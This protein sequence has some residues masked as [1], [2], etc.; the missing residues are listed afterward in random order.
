MARQ[1][2]FPTEGKGIRF[3]KHH[4][5]KHGVQFDKYFAIRYAVDR[6]LK[7]EAIGWSSEGWTLEKVAAIREELLSNI[8]SGNGPQSY[9]EMNE[10]TDEVPT[11]KK[12]IEKNYLERY[13]KK[14]KRTWK[15]DERQLCK[16][17]IPAI[18]SK[19]LDKVTKKDI[20]RIL[21]KAADRG[22]TIGVNRLLAVVKKVFNYAVEQAEIT[23][24]PVAGI[25]TQFA[26]RKRERVLSD[27]EM[28]DL[29][30]NLQKFNPVI[31][32]AIR[33]MLL[34][35]K[36]KGEVVRAEWKHIDFQKR[37]WHIPAKNSKNKRDSIIPLNDMAFSVLHELKKLAGD[38]VYICPPV[39][40]KAAKHLGD[41]SID[42]FMRLH[43]ADLG[44]QGRATPHDLRRTANTIMAKCK[45]LPDIR[46]KILN[47][48]DKSVESEHYDQHDYLSEMRVATDRLGHY[49]QKIVEPQGGAEIISI[50]R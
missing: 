24:S 10:G 22:V 42:Q 40:K 47:H 27:A 18:G 32:A 43:L 39:G 20:I 2:W 49:V 45:V 17:V 36:R 38:C 9:A 33:L 44:L 12:F 34:T 5:R 28:K 50:A 16:D 7:E 25:K 8:K 3:R 37:L 13:A 48:V 19:R 6:S 23:I 35:A 30:E 14:K 31:S 26:E 46:R 4:T 11:V 41:T 1:Q 15:E 21:N 29:F